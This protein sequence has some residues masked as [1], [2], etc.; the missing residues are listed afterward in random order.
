V[1]RGRAG[2]FQERLEHH[3]LAA[4]FGETGAVFFPQRADPSVTV[5]LVDFAAFVTVA[6]IKIAMPLCH[7]ALLWIA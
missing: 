7:G 5:L 4:T 3:V 6:A 1:Q 2:F